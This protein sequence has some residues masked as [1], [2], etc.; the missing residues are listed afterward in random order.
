MGSD[1][2]KDIKILQIQPFILSEKG[3]KVPCENVVI[4]QE[5]DCAYVT[6]P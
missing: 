2:Q 1:Y 4:L 6:L 3:D 5:V